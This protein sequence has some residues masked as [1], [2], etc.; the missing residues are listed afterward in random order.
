MLRLTDLSFSYHDGKRI[1]SSFSL[2]VKAGERV[3]LCGSSGCG[4]T[5]LLRLICGLESPDSGTI[6]RTDHEVCSVVFQEDRLL[7]QKTALE[8]AA[9]HADKD[10]AARWL[11]QFGLEDVLHQPV[12]LLSG[13]MRRRVA[14][15]R[16]AAYGGDLLLLDEPF[17][18]IDEE[19]KHD[20]MALLAA[21]YKD[22]II[23]FTTH[24][25]AEIEAFATRVVSLV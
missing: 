25:T 21:A 17:Q 9:I 12:H 1:L 22:K 18:G 7:M 2:T 19:R 14:I 23:V 20:M 6:E 4:K 8:N 11:R 15:A 24:D 3:A 5:T 10:T 16:A 13:G